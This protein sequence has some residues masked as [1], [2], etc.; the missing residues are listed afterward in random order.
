MTNAGA[1]KDEFVPW[2]SRIMVS[3]ADGAVAMLQGIVGGG[4]LTYYFTR[5]RGLDPGYAGIVWL[6]FGIWNAFNDPLFGYISDRTKH[7][8]GRR[9]PYIRYGAPLFALAFVACWLNLPGTQ[10]DQS[11]MFAQMLV[12]LFA[13]DTL[14]TVIATALYI[15]PYEMA[16]SNKARGSI[17]IWKV[18]FNAL[19][20]AAPLIIIPIIQPGPNQDADPF[21]WIMTAFGVGVGSLIFV[22]TF[23][24][25]EKN[26]QQAEGQFP[27]I[28]S[29]RECFKNFSF[30][31]FEVLSFTVIY[32]QTGLMQG[33]LYYFDELK[34]APIPLFAALGVGV[35][36]GLVA[37][38]RLRHNVKG[39]MRAMTLLFAL[40]CLALA[41]GGGEFIIALACFFLLGLGFSGG[42][43]LVPLMNGDVIDADEHRTGL[44]REGMYAG[45]NSFITKPAISIAQAVFLWIITAFGYN[46]SLDKGLQSASAQMGI[47]IGWGLVPGLLLFLCFVL[48]RWYPL[49]GAEWDRI[50]HALAARHAEKERAV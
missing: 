48:L 17:I 14:Y 37:W 10:T 46:Q 32:V 30:I 36:V 6:L 2:S 9:I 42:M 22:S 29:F 26:F 49:A 20:I 5:W 24:Y 7:K 47:L 33:V 15:M 11:A 28:Q 40:G 38:V 43:F 35:I 34:I 27:I 21:R 18:L 41:F 12:L 4:A 13:F 8:L 44:R 16:I 23:F 31:V 19:A 3:A 39:A 1:I 25:R 50:K 45:V